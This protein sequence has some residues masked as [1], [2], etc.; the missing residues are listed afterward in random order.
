MQTESHKAL[1]AKIR[2]TRTTGLPQ[3]HQVW[4]FLDDGAGAAS[5]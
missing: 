1:V 2:L 5:A 4:A 3:R